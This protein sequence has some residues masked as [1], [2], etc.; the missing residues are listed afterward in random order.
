MQLRLRVDT[1]EG[2]EELVTNLWVITQWERKFKTKLSQIGNGLG[3]EDLGYMAYECS[4]VAGKTVPALFDD[5][6]KKVVALE[7]IDDEQ[8]NPTEGAPTGEA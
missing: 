3:G 8:P 5:Y 4:K 6:L 7:V 2:P 1:G